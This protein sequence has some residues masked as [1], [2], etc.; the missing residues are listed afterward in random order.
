VQGG[1]EV[2]C[3][4]W[5]ELPKPRGRAL[6]GWVAERTQGASSLTQH[7]HLLSWPGGGC[8]ARPH[9]CTASSACTVPKGLES[10]HPGSGRLCLV[11]WN[12]EW[13]CLV[14]WNVEWLCLVIW[15]VEWLCGAYG[16]LGTPT[17]ICSAVCTGSL[18]HMGQMTPHAFGSIVRDTSQGLAGCMEATRQGPGCCGRPF[19]RHTQPKHMAVLTAAVTRRGMPRPSVHCRTIKAAFGCCSWPGHQRR[20]VHCFHRHALRCAV[21]GRVLMHVNQP[22]CLPSCIM[23]HPGIR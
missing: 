7:V 23:W 22:H 10:P 21:A 14:I 19:L 9:G 15:N 20:K 2:C 1:A 8:G 4:L 3:P 12:V 11:V 16:F 17:D 13:L 6:T 5:L 18:Y